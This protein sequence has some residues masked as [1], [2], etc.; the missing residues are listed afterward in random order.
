MKTINSPIQH[1]GFFAWPETYRVSRK[2]DHQKSKDQHREHDQSDTGREESS[3]EKEPGQ[4][5]VMA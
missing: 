1:A 4:I 5:D 2:N 3:P